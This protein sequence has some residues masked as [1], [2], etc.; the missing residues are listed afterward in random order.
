METLND[1]FEAWLEVDQKFPIGYTVYTVVDNRKESKMSEV[2]L[3][4]PLYKVTMT[5]YERGYGQRPM[6][7]KYFD[8]EQ[9]AKEFCKNYFS[10]DSECYFR[11]DYQKIS[12]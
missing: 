11:A 12:G 10:G 6:G 5:E 7:E 3:N 4:G 9:E 8:N 1:L 2:R